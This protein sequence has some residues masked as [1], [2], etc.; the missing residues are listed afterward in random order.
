M[1][2]LATSDVELVVADRRQ[3]TPS[4]LTPVPQ[5]DE[6]V[7]RGE[8]LRHVEGKAGDLLIWHVSLLIS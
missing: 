3:A 6:P 2:I 5:M 8:E 4:M 7:M 1:K